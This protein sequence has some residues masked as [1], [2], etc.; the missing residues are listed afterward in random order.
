M[1]DSE[2]GCVEK[3]DRRIHDRIY[4]AKSKLEQMQ[5]RVPRALNLPSIEYIRAVSIS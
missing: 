4:T 3:K 5:V 1:K 2:R